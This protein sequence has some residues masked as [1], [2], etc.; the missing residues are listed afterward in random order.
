MKKGF[1][2]F[3]NF[4]F[5]L[6]IL[7]FGVAILGIYI[8]E[9]SGKDEFEKFGNFSAG[10]VASIWSLA[11]IILIYIAFLGQKLEL[12][13]QKEELQQNRKKLEETRKV[14]SEQKKEFE[15]QNETLKNQSFENLFFQL[16]RNYSEIVNSMAINV[17]DGPKTGKD[18]L[19]FVYDE[20]LKKKSNWDDKKTANEGK[21]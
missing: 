4:V 8:F 1:H 15:L 6:I 21:N 7:G 13:Y 12:L 17:V 3:G 10:T 5:F 9:M 20:F 2:D 11:G 18:Y 16:I 14:M 19:N